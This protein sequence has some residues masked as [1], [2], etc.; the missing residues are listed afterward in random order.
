[1]RW[2]ALA[3]LLAASQPGRAGEL[4]PLSAVVHVHSDLTTGDF[5]L[6]DLVKDA[7]RQG[8]GALLLAENYLLRIEYGLPPFRALTRV[9]HEEP[10]VLAG[11]VERYLDRVAEVRRQHPRVLILPGIELLP[12]YLWTGSPLS[13]GLTLHDTQNNLLVF[14]LEDPGAL[15]ALPVT[16][17]RRSTSYTWQSALDA[18]PVLLVVPGVALLL[19]KRPRPRRIGRA[20][21]LISRRPWFAGGLLVVLG[22]V[23]A[24]RAWP[25]A[26][27]RYPPWERF[28]L[29]PHQ[30]LIDHVDRLGGVTMWSFPEA[31]DDGQR[32]MGL[33]RVA[34]E[35]Q[36]YVDDLLKTF[37]YAA[38]G[39]LYEQPTRVSEPGG[40]WDRLL[41]QY[42]AGERS[43]PAWALGESGFHGFTAGK[44]LGPVQTV[45]L[46][47][48]RSERGVLEAL[49]R[50]RLYAL[51]RT[52]ELGLQLGDF[53][54]TA[55]G[56]VA[57]SGDRLRVPPGTPLEVQVAVEASDGSA[58]AIRV[59]LVRNG[60]PVEAWAGQTPFR[61]LYR[62][63]TGDQPLVFRL[64]VHS[65]SPHRLLTS[66]IFV[67]GPGGER[68]GVGGAM[69][70]P[71]TWAP[72]GAT[73]YR[74]A[75]RLRRGA[76]SAGG[77]G[78]FE[79]PKRI[80][81]AMSGPPTFQ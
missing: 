1:M 77:L 70:G 54:V 37:R 19:R 4:E 35:T 73:E 52:P 48:E 23:A 74:G 46:V 18:V 43:R 24:V 55:A 39:A 67:V 16:S 10:S 5:P 47:D 51:M 6:A 12:H 34:W 72:V 69:S 36:P 27:D 22:L 66:P 71:P 61:A 40:I 32:Q 3:L 49:R 25:F 45:F 78:A 31:A 59:T 17:N 8:I 80:E 2:V 64:D 15:R 65:R 76:P 63:T 26:V 50:G 44:R 56:T 13:L 68:G 14:G 11:G 53:S 9:V 42:A 60:A 33:V 57:R 75:P 29:E 21:V 30:A 41:A 38:F 81:R 58:Q 7:E 62:D 28:G 79:A 20:V